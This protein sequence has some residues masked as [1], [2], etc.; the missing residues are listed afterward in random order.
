MADADVVAQF[1]KDIKTLLKQ[2]DASPLTVTPSQITHVFRSILSPSSPSTPAQTSALLVAMRLR[3]VDRRADVIAGMV[4]LMKEF[5]HKV[6][7]REEW[8][9]GFVDIVGTGGDGQNTF[10][11]STTAAIVVGGCGVKVCKHG[12]KASTSASGSAD[13]LIS[14]GCALNSLTYDTLPRIFPSTSFA[15][16]YAPLYHPSLASVAPIRSSI[17]IPT[18]FNILG[19][20]L[21][22]VKVKARILGVHSEWLGSVYAE[23][24]RLLGAERGMVVW[25]EEGLDELSIAGPSRVWI[26][27]STR[28]EGYRTETLTPEDFG[29]TRHP[30]SSVASGTPT[31]NAALLKKILVGEVG[32]EEPVM[33]FILLN[34]AALLVV[35]GVAGGWKEGVE[36]AWQSVVNG[37]AREALEGFAKVSSEV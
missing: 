35:A 28:P 29:L 34:A 3:E 20:L 31:E 15:F 14:F 36:V 10:N 19:P 5:G 30:L 6:E 22:P 25:G 17:G 2:I 23:A 8:G 13:I 37:G 32:R 18:I 33:Q 9:D 12:N 26:L 7:H 4:E 11:V 1:N 21:N 24:L 27:D 16:L